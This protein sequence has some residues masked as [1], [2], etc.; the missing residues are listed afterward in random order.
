MRQLAITD[1]YT[2]LLLKEV[3]DGIAKLIAR[4][5][6]A[7]ERYHVVAREQC[8]RRGVHQLWRAACQHHRCSATVYMVPHG[9]WRVDDDEERKDPDESVVFS[10]SSEKEVE[11]V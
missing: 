3:K 5:E 10:P 8:G 11:M 1:P 4:A 7:H 6:Q 9:L 2:T